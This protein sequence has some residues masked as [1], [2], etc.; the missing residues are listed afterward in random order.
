MAESI[1]IEKAPDLGGTG[2]G[3][4]K[5]ALKENSILRQ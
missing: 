1:A 4:A 3:Y 5:N 2:V